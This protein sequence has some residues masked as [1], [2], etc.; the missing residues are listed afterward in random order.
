MMAMS[1]ARQ[2][3][4]AVVVR[5]GEGELIDAAAVRHQF[6][7]TGGQ[8]AGRLGFEQFLVPPSTLGARPHVHQAHD[9]T[10]YVLQGRLTVATGTGEVVLDPGDLAHAPRGSIHG[11]RN[12]SQDVAVLALCVYTPPG[13]EQYFRDVHAAVE[14]GRELTPEL[15]QELRARYRT[16]SL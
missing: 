16:E 15:L 4:P 11:F 3:P 2:R 8:S 12:A 9:E 1:R 5:A 7:L 6:K 13:Y 10:F 14:T